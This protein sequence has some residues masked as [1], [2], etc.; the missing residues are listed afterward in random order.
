MN[1]NILLY[2][3][4]KMSRICN[5]KGCK[6]NKSFGFEG[7]KLQ[8]CNNHK[9]LGMIDIKHKKC[10]NEEC[11]TIPNFALPGQKPQYC[12]KHKTIDMVNV[13]DKKCSAKGCE[14]KNRYSDRK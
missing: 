5:F 7:N 1:F 14:T 10:I 6:L 4:L 3:K 11:D 8:F 13:V 2:I 12:A 9:L